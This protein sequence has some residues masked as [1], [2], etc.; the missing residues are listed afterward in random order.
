MSVEG[1]ALNV[2]RSAPRGAV[3]LSYASQD[4]EAARRIC[5]SLRSG[6]V[7]VWFDAD[8]GL[9]HG[10]EWDTKIRRQIKECVLFIP[11]ISASTQARLEGYFRIEWELA[12]E[13]A[14]GIASGVPFILPVVID[15]TREPEALVPD[16]FRKVQWTRLPG[17][18]VPPD[19][20]A[21]LLKLWSHRVGVLAHN[22]GHTR[23]PVYAPPVSSPMA[24]GETRA[25]G[26]GG[27]V[28]G[29]T[30]FGGRRLAAIV[31]TDA[32]GY[33][34]RM[35]VDEAGTLAL[36]QS[37]FE[38]MRRQ[39]AQHGGQVLKSTGDGLL[40]C[41]DSVVD[42]VT[43]ALAIQ[44]Q[45]AARGTGALQHRM[46]VHLGDVYHQAGDVAG[47][48]VNLAARLQ[49]AAQPGTICV[50]DAVFAAVKGKVAMESVALAPL[51]LKNIAQPLPAHLIAPVGTRLVAGVVARGARS[52]R[53]WAF[54]AAGVALLAAAAAFFFRRTEKPAA[55][56][57]A[58]VA[59]SAAPAAEFPR[60][61]A[62]KQARRL[63]FAVD[64]IAEDFALADDLVKPLLAAQPNDPEVVTVAAEVSAE[65]LTRGFDQ[66]PPRLAQA[67]RL[68]ERAVQL[69]PDNPA[70]LAA[71][72]RYLRSFPTQRGRA[73]A[74]LRR[75]IALD[76]KEP[77]FYRALYS[78][79]ILTK[80][81]PETDAFGA[82]MAALFPHDPLVVYEIALLHLSAGD[83]AAVEEGFDK[84]L[85]L[86]PVANA[87]TWKA[88]M[89]LE[90]HG[91]VAGMKLWLDR[92]PERQRTNARLAIAYAVEALVTG[93][94]LPARHLIESITDT[95]LADGTYIFPRE[96]LLGDLEQLDGHNDVARLHYEAALKDVQQKLAG[97]PKDL[98]PIRA[99]LWIQLGLGHREEARTALRFNVQRRPRPYRWNMNLTWWT[100]SLRACLLLDERAEA[101][102][103][104]REACAEPQ[105]RLLLRNLF[106]VDPK[107]APFRDDPEIVALLAEPKTRESAAASSVAVDD[108]SASAD[109]SVVVLPFENLSADP[110]N[111]LLTEGLHTEII[112]NLQLI[113]DLKVISRTRAVAFKGSTA[114]NAEIAQ[115]LGVANVVTGSVRREQDRVRIQLE[116]RRASDD[117]LLWRL[118]QGDHDAK[119]A[120]ALQT[121]IAEQVAQALQAREVRGGAS[122][123]AKLMTRNPRAY[124]MWV[125]AKKLPSDKRVAPCEEILRLDPNFTL[126]ASLLSTTHAKL[127]GPD[128]APTER[129]RHASEAKRWAEAAS[130]MAPGGAGD[131]ALAYYYFRIERDGR[132]SLAFAEN[133]IRA[134]PYDAEGF[135]YA[136]LALV[137]L[138]RCAEAVAQYRHA[139]ELDPESPSYAYNLAGAVGRL[140]RWEELR[141][142][143]AEMVAKGIPDERHFADADRFTS[144]GELPASLEG[145]SASD[146]LLWLWRG[147][148][149][150]EM[151][152]LIDAELR[153]PQLEDPQRWTIRCTQADVYLRLGQPAEAAAAAREALAVAERLQSGPEIGPTEKPGWLAGAM[154]RNGRDEEGI[155]AAQRSVAAASPDS[156]VLLRWKREIALAKIYAYAKRP[157]ECV[158]LLAKLLRKPCELTVPMLR[159]EPDWDNVREDAEFKAL[160]ADPKNSA[161]L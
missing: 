8:G 14:M 59:N 1:S 153:R 69:A 156:Q 72:G 64:S 93:Q 133:L 13:R 28:E 21:R 45:F 37:D 90:V 87:I 53:G 35:Q 145:A 11:V 60:D 29:V 74:L 135:S 31:F 25:P 159:V 43:C 76:P 36:L 155:A 40:L 121:E 140:R 116:L 83:L 91:D 56:V 144:T 138:G 23:R 19:V 97:D 103:E 73:E 150:A 161:P 108:K 110:A 117:A 109:K 107:M 154:V 52:R 50:S 137:D 128:A 77:R 81:G 84:T 131:G 98:R 47:D 30:A 136:G 78:V 157:R 71:L 101:L 44:A 134:L 17:G 58:P 85:K 141:Q 5:E 100:S 92:M 39:C 99:E 10:D 114:S 70:A 34:A 7:D 119:D 113:S 148:R 20:Q 120:L 46:G 33:S 67:Q 129:L 115:R 51:V 126:A 54:A 38:Q 61:P 82:R 102:A 32:V 160:L 12:A 139:I 94:T 48:G 86:A 132:R 79:L 15:D 16:R 95:W 42:A 18:V 22:D 41:F 149:L 26:L 152:A 3:F 49:T 55:A 147:R 68:G 57:A 146:R 105:G 62:L 106:R 96:L 9:E 4:A 75:A 158:E 130:R 63:I 24:P 65:Y 112:S 125:A 122:T 127:T 104:L 88:K 118:P 123:F 27:P 143:V 2:E 89:M 66:T 124:E 6:G 151:P 80:P 111:A 142:A